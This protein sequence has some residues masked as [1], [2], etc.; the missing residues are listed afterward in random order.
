MFANVFLPAR[1][2]RARAHGTATAA[3]GKGLSRP[4][5]QGM[6]KQLRAFIAALAPRRAGGVW[7]DYAQANSYNA[8]AYE[9]KRAFVAR[10][11]GTHRPA[12]LLDVGCNTGDF[13]V[14][15]LASG[16]KV[17]VGIEGDVDTLDVAFRRARQ[18]NLAFLP[19]YQ[20]LA[21]PSPAQGWNGRERGAIHDRLKADAVLALAVMHHLALARNVPL[22]WALDWLL[23][24]AP[25]GVVE[26]VP[27][28]DPM[29]VQLLGGRTAES[30]GY[31]E[32][33]FTHHLTQRA[34]VRETLDLPGSG[35]RLYAFER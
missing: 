5:L 3:S 35:R 25:R 17:A 26:F 11:A 8:D 9:R 33:I 2:Q 4:V 14:A 13:S 34:A 1:L 31:S 20:D 16:A 15:A 10:F 24:L 28:D 18:D 32:T 21:N 23:A 6:L 30:L 29:A 19:L 22:P 12:T 7:E 27:P